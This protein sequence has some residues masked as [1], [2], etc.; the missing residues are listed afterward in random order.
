MR[1]GA[2]RLGDAAETLVAGR[3][4]AAGWIVH[5]R[6]VRVGR[7]EVDLIATDPGPPLALVFVE[8]RWRAR[9]DFG[10]A[11]ETVGHR[12]RDGLRRAAFRLIG[13]EGEGPRPP[14]S[15]GRPAAAHLPAL[16]RLPIRFDLVVVEPGDRIRH[17]RHAW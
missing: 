16:P 8:V 17:H 14:A 12:K 3:L 6:N 15:V 4:A 2:Q 5:A 11:E 13:E 1:T 7:D 10:L 9:R